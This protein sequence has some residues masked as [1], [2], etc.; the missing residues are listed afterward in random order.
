MSE[1]A[2]RDYLAGAGRYVNVIEGVGTLRLIFGNFEDD[3]ILVQTF[4][5]VGDL[6]LAEGVAERVVN[7]GHVDAEARSGVAV[8]D[9]RTLQAADLLIGVDVVNTGNFLKTLH[10]NGRPVVE[11]GHAF[12]L[13]RIL[14]L[15]ATEASADAEI[16]NGLQK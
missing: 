9:Q 2:E 11:F 13:K 10:E 7:V 16:L 4:V 14:I 6:A 5:D 3:V 12:G 1:G 15:R 8:N